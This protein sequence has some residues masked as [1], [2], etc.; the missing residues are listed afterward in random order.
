MPWALLSRHT[1][2]YRHDH[3]AGEEPDAVASDVSAI[4]DDLCNLCGR[5]LPLHRRLGGRAACFNAAQKARVENAGVLTASG[6]IA[7]EALLG[8]IWQ[9]YNLCRNGKH[10][11]IRRRFSVIRLSDWRLDRFAGLRR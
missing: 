10:R 5:L 2:R 1:V 4:W 11:T 7:G 3:D 6:L 9:D 8:L